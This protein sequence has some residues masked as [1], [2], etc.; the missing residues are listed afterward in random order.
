MQLWESRPLLIELSLCECEWSLTATTSV[1]AQAGGLRFDT[2]DK[3]A[4]YGLRLWV[5]Q[6]FRNKTVTI[7]AGG[8]PGGW[9]SW[10]SYSV[11]WWMSGLMHR[12][13]RRNCSTVVYVFV[14]ATPKLIMSLPLM[15]FSYMP[16]LN[17]HRR[18]TLTYFKR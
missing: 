8:G 5:N 10:F 4:R 6:N 12:L 15:A 1:A 11:P 3:D 16:L 14:V 13:C 9:I 2:T 7:L 17:H 18:C